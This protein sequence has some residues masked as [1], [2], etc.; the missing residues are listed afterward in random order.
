MGSGV[1]SRFLLVVFPES[2]V[3][4]ISLSP[5][6]VVVGVNFFFRSCH[7]QNKDNCFGSERNAA[8]LMPFVF[9]SSIRRVRKI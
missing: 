4:L 1:L 3:S 6:L 5:I 8:A 9:S 2:F 7:S